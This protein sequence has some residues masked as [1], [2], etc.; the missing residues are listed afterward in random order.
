MTDNR[1]WGS[2]GNVD[3]GLRLERSPESALMQ[4]IT[5]LFMRVLLCYSVSTSHAKVS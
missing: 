3:S 5:K 2:A 1:P 4:S